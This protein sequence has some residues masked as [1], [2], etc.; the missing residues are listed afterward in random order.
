M[1]IYAVR[2]FFLLDRLIFLRFDLKDIQSVFIAVV[3]ASVRTAAA[4]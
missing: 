2:H 1:E 3:E 4:T